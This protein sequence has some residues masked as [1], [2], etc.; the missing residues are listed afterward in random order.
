MVRVARG[1]V[2]QGVIVFSEPLR[3]P[4]GAEVMVS[5][6]TLSVADPIIE[7]AT[8]EDFASVFGMWADR[9]DM[10]DSAAYVRR[11]RQQWQQ[12]ALRQD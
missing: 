6:E 7:P 4:E 3:L 5:I 10:A 11:S 1:R 12:R 9:E 8:D 2:D